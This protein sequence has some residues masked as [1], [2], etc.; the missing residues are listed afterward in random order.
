MIL[1][2]TEL[3]HY[4]NIPNSVEFL[5]LF[6]NQH[7]GAATTIEKV[8]DF[9]DSNY[10]V[11]TYGDQVMETKLGEREDLIRK[12]KMVESWRYS[13]YLRNDNCGFF[14]VFGEVCQ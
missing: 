3:P 8:C 13:R 4:S 5:L 7:I 10:K 1:Q 2:T 11:F 12:G 9:V 14:S 6:R